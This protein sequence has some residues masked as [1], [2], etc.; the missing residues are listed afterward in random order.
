M[1]FLVSFA[2]GISIGLFFYVGLWL[3]VRALASARF[4]ALI[5]FPS[6]LI[7]SAIALA[8]FLLAI[9]HEWQRAVIWIAGFAAARWI[10]GAVVARAGGERCT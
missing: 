3:T 10:V 2:A 5:A 7:R 9:D 1:S 8:G 4:G 6:F